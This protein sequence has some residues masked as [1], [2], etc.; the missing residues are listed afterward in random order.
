MLG[1]T[2]I[3]KLG[4]NNSAAVVVVVGQSALVA[5]IDGGDRNVGVSETLTLN[6]GASYDPDVPGGAATGLLFEW[7]C[8]VLEGPGICGGTLEETVSNEQVSAGRRRPH[9][10]T[11]GPRPHRRNA[12]V[13]TADPP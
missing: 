9:R 2:V 1:V 3:D 7:S 10:R 6:A 4:L 11:G 12:A 13:R 5:A 8:E